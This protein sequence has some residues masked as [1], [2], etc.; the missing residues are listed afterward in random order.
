MHQLTDCLIDTILQGW[1]ATSKVLPGEDSKSTEPMS[2]PTTDNLTASTSPISKSLD[3]YI[4]AGKKIL[5]GKRMETNASGI[6]RSK[7]RMAKIVNSNTSILPF[8]H[9]TCLNLSVLWRF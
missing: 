7:S 8:L 9:Q 4:E 5:I 2:V 3:E 1:G 6:L